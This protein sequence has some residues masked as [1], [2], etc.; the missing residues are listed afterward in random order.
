MKILEKIG[1]MVR[2]QKFRSRGREALSEL[3]DSTLATKKTLRPR[4]SS[5]RPRI[6]E[7]QPDLL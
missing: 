5:G 2:S 3:C 6:E 4:V 7:D 1:S